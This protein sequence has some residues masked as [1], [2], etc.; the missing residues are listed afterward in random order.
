MSL[1]G[2]CTRQDIS[3]EGC[4]AE[5]RG[6]STHPD[7]R[8]QEMAKA[9]AVTQDV[10]MGPHSSCHPCFVAEH[11]QVDIFLHVEASKEQKHT[12]QME[13]QKLHWRE[14]IASEQASGRVEAWRSGFPRPHSGIPARPTRLAQKTGSL[15]SSLQLFTRPACHGT[16][17]RMS[18]ISTG[19][20]HDVSCD[21][22][23]TSPA[24][25]FA[26]SR[27]IRRPFLAAH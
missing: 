16:N 19:C 3:E 15:L 25:L 7:G 20:A 13:E 9:A 12:T 26:P 1:A 24:R 2:A 18:W 5:L 6:G 11:R 8:Q 10:K 14:Q 27:L 22:S 23:A 17:S 21:R 4:K